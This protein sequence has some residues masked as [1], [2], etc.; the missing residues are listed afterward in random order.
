[1]GL[2][3]LAG[4]ACYRPN[5]TDGGF[6]CNVDAGPSHE[7]PEGFTCDR[8]FSPPLCWK[9][10]H[11]AGPNQ[12]RPSEKPP[13]GGQ[14]AEAGVDADAGPSCFDAM[15]ACDPSDAGVCD[16]FC[17]TGCGCREKCSASAADGGG[18]S[19]TC[20]A[21]PAG[22]GA[23]YDSCDVQRN[24]CG[25]GL[26]CLDDNCG[27]RCYAYCRSDNDCTTGN[28]G[29]SCTR[30]APGGLLV[31]DVPFVDSCNPVGG[32]PANC[33]KG[34]QGCYISSSR[35]THTLCDCPGGSHPDD[36]CTGSRSCLFGSLCVDATGAGTATCQ[37]VCRLDGGVQD[38][39]QPQ[40]CQIFVGND[41]S[42]P[43]NPTY[44]FCH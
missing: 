10:P 25:P 24:N 34:N 1:L 20:V 5:I 19:F 13:D 31:C 26:V 32:S 27:G 33:P 44:G 17:R 22:A 36:P 11:D 3:A 2:A 29:S 8:T 6:V 39:P 9:G 12:D 21:V 30:A 41:A 37:R 16:P 15:P 40:T 7:C 43:P 35:P 38:C 4:L 14:D 28:V 18:A 42:N 23:L